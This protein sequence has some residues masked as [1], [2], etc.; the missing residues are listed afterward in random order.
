WRNGVQHSIPISAT[1]NVLNYINI[2][3]SLNYTERWTSNSIDKQYDYTANKV[4]TDTVWGFNRVWDY[5]A[6]VS[7]SSKLYGYFQPLPFVNKLL[8]ERLTMIRHVLT[9][10]VYFS[11]RP[12]FGEEKYGY[13]GRYSYYDTDSVLQTAQYSRYSNSLYGVP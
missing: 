10:S 4:M 9:P 11:Y 3:P 12:D 13:Y 2:T 8:G 7:A 1:F 6:S 5:S